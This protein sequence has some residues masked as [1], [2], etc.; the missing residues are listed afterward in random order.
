MRPA[1]C[2]TS[3]AAVDNWHR[4]RH[5]AGVGSKRRKTELPAELHTPAGSRPAIR[6]SL[7][8]GT[9]THSGSLGSATPQLALGVDTAFACVRL[10]ADSTAGA[11]WGEWRG[12]TELEPSRIVR[13]PMAQL[14]RRE[15]TWLV[16]ATLALYNACVLELVGRD[17]EGVPESLVPVNP[18][19]IGTGP[20]GEMTIDGVPASSGDYFIMRRAL[21]PALTMAEAAVL[22][23][24]R[25]YFAAGLAASAYSADWWISGGAPVTVLTSD[26][27]ISAADAELYAD[28]WV[29]RRALGPS[30]PAVMGKGL[31]A[32]AFGADIGT[33]AA[34]SAMADIA[35]SI[36]RYF[37]VPPH[38]VAAERAGGSSLTYTNT[39]SEGVH[40]A[41]YTVAGYADTIAD[42]ISE[43]LPGDYIAGRVAR[44]NLSHLTAPEM[45]ARFRAW[46]EAIAAGWMTV[47]EVREREGL[48][49]MEDA[50]E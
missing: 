41:R 44:L 32:E 24:A 7:S 48:A 30:V 13:R 25:S 35:T 22:S 26:Q 16:T 5:R 31:K 36:T 19:R 4:R 47:D 2:C 38:L 23:L 15:W 11:E 1:S 12:T 37:G 10:I 21:F 29:E 14:T 34:A 33:D 42:C 43:L 27:V 40:F 18:R 20:S 50:A 45:G 9:F 28:R 3:L 8:G 49:P 46:G 6:H 39:E 17:S